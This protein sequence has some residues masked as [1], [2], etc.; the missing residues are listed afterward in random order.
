MGNDLNNLNTTCDNYIMNSHLKRV[1]M[2]LSDAVLIYPFKE[3]GF[4]KFAEVNQSACKIY[5]Y[6]REEFLKLD[7][8]AINSVKDSIARG[9]IEFRKRLKNEGSIT[10]KGIHR[11]KT[12]HTFPVELHSTI[13]YINNVQYIVTIAKSLWKEQQEQTHKYARLKLNDRLLKTQN[14]MEAMEYSISTAINLTDMEMGCIYLIDEE[15]GHIKIEAQR[16]LPESYLSRYSYFHAGTPQARSVKRGE[17]II[18]Q[19]NKLNLPIDSNDEK[20][21]KCASMFPIEYNKKIVA[22]IFLVSR[23]RTN[24]DSFNL[25]SLHLILGNIGNTI[26]RIQAVNRLIE[27]ERIIDSLYSTLPGIAFRC[28]YDS[29]YTMESLSDAIYNITGYNKEELIN[30][31]RKSYIS[32]IHPEDKKNIF[33]E[34]SIQLKNKGHYKINYRIITKENNILWVIEQGIAIKDKDGYNSHFE[35]YIYDI[36]NTKQNEEQILFSK[37]QLQLKKNLSNYFI[38]HQNSSLF[39][40]ILT[41][42]KENLSSHSGV[43]GYIDNNGDIIAPATCYTRKDLKTPDDLIIYKHQWTGVFGKAL[44]NKMSIYSNSFFYTPINNIY[45]ERLMVSPILYKEKLIGVIVLGDKENEY[46]SKDL[47]ILDSITN[48][49]S[50]LLYSWLEERFFQKQ[51][52]DAKNKAEEADRLK[53][54]F[55]ATMS[56]E[57]RTPLNAIIGFSEIIDKDTNFDE[58]LDYTKTIH[59][60]GNNLLA[61]IEDIF[62]LALLESDTINLRNGNIKIQQICTQNELF[63]KQLLK[64]VGKDKSITLKLNH[65]CS[66]LNQTIFNDKFKINQVLSNLIKNAVKFTHSGF[67]ELGCYSSSNSMLTFYVKDSGIGISKNNQEIIFDLF[68]QIDDSNTRSYDGIGIGL[69]ISNLIAEAMNGSITIK[70]EIGEGSIF[71]FSIPFNA[72]N[73]S[74]KLSFHKSKFITSPN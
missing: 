47:E 8:S 50:P 54:N 64:E 25:N 38:N 55:L 58:V 29:L 27:S 66:L 72:N 60:C 59:E 18:S 31:K 26:L 53:S 28:K 9:S 20:T 24:I 30:N 4:T 49:I 1:M 52:I 63:A 45:M 67:I 71:Y 57:L 14:I 39:L 65:D 13:G 10:S 51:L 17:A 5:G 12:G 23:H 37:T 15:T 7:P 56:H 3:D 35:G 36:T 40:K 34:I 2:H 74:N 22:C 70:S 68:R 21:F 69:T 61:I 44:K 42:V 43:I 46:T 62:D 19:Y 73:K 32:I 48:Y 11:T 16:N 33:E 6:T 41:L